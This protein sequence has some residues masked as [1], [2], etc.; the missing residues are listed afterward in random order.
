M[1]KTVKQVNQKL[2]ELHYAIRSLQEKID[3]EY[4]NI[5]LYKKEI[6]MITNKYKKEI[7]QSEL[8]FHGCQGQRDYWCKMDINQQSGLFV[9]ESNYYNWTEKEYYQ[10]K[11]KLE[12]KIKQINNHYAENEEV[13][14]LKESIENC[15]V[16]IELCRKEIKKL[17]PEY[18][19]EVRYGYR[20]DD[21]SYDAGLFAI[22]DKN[23]K[24]F[25]DV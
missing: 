6:E 25:F 14:K 11:K 21:Y 22:K 1:N 20:D 3:N 7:E 13:K 5:K 17:S 4:Y 9:F 18:E 12:D 23:N 24:Y 16:R 10:N 15:E 8:E 2:R 19:R